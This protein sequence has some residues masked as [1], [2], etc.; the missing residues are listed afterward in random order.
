MFGKTKEDHQRIPGVCS[1]RTAYINVD[2]ITI[3]EISEERNDA[4]EFD[5]VIKP[6]YD[7]IDSLKGIYRR[8]RFINKKR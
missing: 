2:N 5:W 8:L 6:Y 4:D 1:I 7:V 3:D